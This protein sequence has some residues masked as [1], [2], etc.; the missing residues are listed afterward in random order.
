MAIKIKLSTGEEIVI[1]GAVLSEVNKAFSRALAE[2]QAL[3]IRNSSGRVLALN[4][5]QI[6]SLEQVPDPVAV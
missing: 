6:L 5:R 1:R 4:P 3:E 2:D